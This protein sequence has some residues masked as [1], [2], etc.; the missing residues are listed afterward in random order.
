MVRVTDGN[1]QRISG[2]SYR[3]PSI[4]RAWNA[5]ATRFWVISTN[6]TAIPFAF[7]P[8]SA[9]AVPLPD[10]LPFNTEPSFSTV[11]PNVMYGGGNQY[12]NPTVVRY[13]FATRQS[14]T[15]V[16]L[17]TLV[18]GLTNPRT[19]LRD[20]MTGG[21]ATENLQV[22]FG[23]T[24]QDSDRYV[25]WTPIGDLGSR[26]IL[27]TMA[28]TINGV[29]TSVTL[30]FHVHAAVLDE[31]GRY[32]W[33]TPTAA[34]QAAPR[35]APAG[36]VWDTATGRISMISQLPGGHGAA[37]WGMYVNHDCCTSSAW[38]AGQ[39]QIRPLA[40]PTGSHDM[41]APVLTPQE[42]YLSDHSSWHNARPEVQTPVIVATY[43]YGNNTS[44]W[45]AWDDEVIAIQTDAAPGV[46]ATVWRFAH[47]RSN[48]AKDNDPTNYEFWY[49]PR[50][51]VSPDGR[52]AIF[53][54]N[55]EK[56]LGIDS[57]EGLHR[58]DVF[59]VKLQ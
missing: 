37:G 30:N 56:T 52:W 51:S 18:S 3:S 1:T 10:S 58:Q 19:Y 28:S 39:W 22:L 12:V 54:S 20:V 6:G 55:W 43:R 23:G 17:T 53:T 34:D 50:P 48:V 2:Q 38:D 21:N 7:N 33:L 46:G 9:Q 47:H 4:G 11:N 25:L 24:G 29:G 13:D 36:V 40:I 49:T 27:D 32:I 57:I 5:N 42:V 41:I 14:A 45:R 31:S 8:S 15:V 35:L 44:P 26:K 16:D 59:L